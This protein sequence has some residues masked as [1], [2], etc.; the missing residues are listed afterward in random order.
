MKSYDSPLGGF[1]MGGASGMQMTATQMQHQ[2]LIRSQNGGI[3]GSGMAN[4]TQ[5][6]QLLSQQHQQQTLAMQQNNNQMSLQMQMSQASSVG[7]VNATGTGM[8]PYKYL[9]N[10]TGRL[11]NYYI[12]S[13]NNSYTSKFYAK[14][15]Q[16]HI[17]QNLKPNLPNLLVV[18]IS[19]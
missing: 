13:N 4:S 15:F 9:E 8:L 2:Q 18:I 16:H 7:Q 11:R 10:I 6:Q 14:F 1:G 19:S 3:T 17:N 12:Y 5:M